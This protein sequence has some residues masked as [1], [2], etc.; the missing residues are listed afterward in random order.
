MPAERKSNETEQLEKLIEI[1]KDVD[2]VML[3]SIA[4]DG[5]LVARPM[6]TQELEYDGDLWFITK[7]DTDKYS[8]VEAN[9]NVNISVVGKSY[10]SIS[11]K[12]EF[13]DDRQRLE[14]HWNKIYEEIFD[15]D[16]NDPN[17]VMVKIEMDS[18]EYWDTGNRSGMLVNFFKNLTKNNKPD[19][20]DDL[21]QTIDMD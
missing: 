19:D 5:K 2:V 6:Q 16:S 9:P 17:L 21:N 20:S 3:T 15:T 13:I 7:K 18:A 10:A 4:A 11:G 12:A 8:E 14:K 1:I